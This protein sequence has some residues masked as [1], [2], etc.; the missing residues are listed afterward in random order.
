[1][2]AIPDRKISGRSLALARFSVILILSFS[3]ACGSDDEAL[4]GTN[5]RQSNTGRLRGGWP[6]VA[7][8]RA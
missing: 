8:F 2:P 4:V 1:M 5:A 3:A 6:P 7:A